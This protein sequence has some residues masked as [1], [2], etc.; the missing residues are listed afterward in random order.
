MVSGVIRG[1]TL[2]VSD[3]GASARFW[4]SVLGIDPVGHSAQ[5]VWMDE[6]APGVRLILQAVSE[7]KSQKN[8]AHLDLT[9]AD[10][11]ALIERIRQLGGIR[12]EDVDEPDYALTVM[13]D[14]DGYEFCVSRRLSPALRSGGDMP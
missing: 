12:L 4:S 14:P 3:L 2:D 9:A 5:Y 10:P 6:V 11:D 7:P 13:A 8:R 1:I